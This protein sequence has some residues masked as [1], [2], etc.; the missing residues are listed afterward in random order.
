MLESN[1]LDEGESDAYLVYHVVIAPNLA[2]KKLQEAYKCGEPTD[3]VKA[4][5]LPG[6]L[7]AVS[8]KVLALSGYGKDIKSKVHEEL[9]N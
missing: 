3:I 1:K 8:R 2:D 9:K 6:E 7:T 5:F 4:L